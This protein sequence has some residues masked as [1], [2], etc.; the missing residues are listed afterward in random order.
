M[1]RGL[2]ALSLV[3]AALAA[4]PATATADQA[5]T[6]AA[7]IS[8]GIPGTGITTG[9]SCSVEDTPAALGFVFAEGRAYGVPGLM[10]GHI[11]LER[12]S[13]GAVL[14]TRDCGPVL[15]APPFDFCSALIIVNAVPGQRLRA[16]CSVTGVLGLST[17]VACSLNVP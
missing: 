1:R 11:S 10:S 8:V 17:R 7:P 6:V 9:P 12:V 2:L 13:D 3:S 5:C 16:R 15:T 14:A 4:S